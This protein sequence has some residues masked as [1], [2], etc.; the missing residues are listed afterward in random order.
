MLQKAIDFSFKM[1][2]RVSV[3]LDPSPLSLLR[4]SS[5]PFLAIT[6]VRPSPTPHRAHTRTRNPYR[7]AAATSTS[8]R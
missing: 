3:L 2:D 1:F 8:T 6:L 7:T 5:V 4:S